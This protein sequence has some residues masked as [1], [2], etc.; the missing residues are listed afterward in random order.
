[1]TAPPRV[2]DSE[3]LAETRIRL[4]LGVD[5]GAEVFAGHFEEQPVLP[6]VAQIDWAISLAGR[7]LGLAGAFS[8]ME[9]IKFHRIIQ[10]P[11]QV[12]LY[13]DWQAARG[14]LLFEYREDADAPTCS[15]GCLRFQR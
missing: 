8:G 12:R 2:T 1:M 15:S 11:A 14:R 4:T 10:P 9:K 6:G 7:Y 3:R 13:L 5:P